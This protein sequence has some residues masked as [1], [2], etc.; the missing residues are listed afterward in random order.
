RDVTQALAAQ[1]KGSDKERDWN[2]VFDWLAL[3]GGHDGQPQGIDTLER[4]LECLGLALPPGRG[5]ASRYTAF[6]ASERFRFIQIGVD[7]LPSATPTVPIF[8]SLFPTVVTLL[9]C[10]DAPSPQELLDRV[11]QHEVPQP[12][13][14]LLRGPLDVAY[15]ASIR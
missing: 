1:L 7:L 4:A 10:A 9:I 13:L 8:G 12:L 15:R 3:W 6:H 11:S 2:R 14:V 5:P